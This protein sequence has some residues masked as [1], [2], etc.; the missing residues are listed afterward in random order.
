MG[1]KTFDHVLR[2]QLKLRLS[3][4]GCGA[5]RHIKFST[6]ALEACH[7]VS[8]TCLKYMSSRQNRLA[9]MH[10]SISGLVAAIMEF[11]VPVWLRSFLT[12]VIE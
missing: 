7:T 1:V 2:L 12:T 5:G 9:T 6:S 4:F 8:L 10:T 3:Y 11:I